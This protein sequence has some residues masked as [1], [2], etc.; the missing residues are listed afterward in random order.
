MTRPLRLL[1]GLGLLLFMTACTKT[2]YPVTTGSYRT[3][4]Q[5]PTRLVVWGP[6]Q[7][8]AETAVAT[9]LQKRGL[10]VVEREQL[11]RV[12]DEHTPDRSP[13]SQ[14]ETAVLQAAHVLGV[15]TLVFVDT[16]RASMS[17]QGHQTGRPIDLTARHSTTVAIRGV[18]VKT[19]DTEW[20]A[21]ASYSPITHEHD[22]A[23]TNLACQALATVWGFRPAGYHEVPSADMC[24]IK[25]PRPYEPPSG[26][27]EELGMKEPSDSR[28]AMIAPSRFMNNAG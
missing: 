9:W 11:Q 10:V 5:Q 24:Q 28:S 27:Y 18:D 2:V 20:N 14:D 23:L 8:E 21:Q 19:G 17:S 3:L 7:V 16:S 22:G 25:M 6:T 1:I 15:D 4:P 26:R 13:H 12:L